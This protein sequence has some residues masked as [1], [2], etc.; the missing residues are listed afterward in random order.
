MP[1]K[2]EASRTTRGPKPTLGDTDAENDDDTAFR[3][4][5]PEDVTDYGLEF[6]SSRLEL[7]DT[8][9]RR[10]STLRKRTDGRPADTT[11]SSDE[12]DQENRQPAARSAGT[13]RMAH[14][15]GSRPL[16]QA[17]QARAQAPASASGSRPAAV[18]P[19]ARRRKPSNPKSKAQR[20]DREIRRLQNYPG[21]LIPK[22]AFARLVR[23][24][25]IKHSQGEPMRVT[26]G[27]LLAMQESSEIFL[28]QRFTDS[29]LLT[30]H[31]QRVT[32][33]VRDMALMAM[34]CDR[35]HS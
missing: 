31:R 33:E 10:C 25:I 29:Y 1:R 9:N 15:Q 19:P 20:M 28:T 26:E 30:K 34:I 14:Q 3:S 18:Q 27:A 22:L 4:P 8:A 17:Q 21:L 2:S 24:L 7:Q 23:E 32:L 6:T 11:S 16:A 12:E 5:D 13:R 35:A